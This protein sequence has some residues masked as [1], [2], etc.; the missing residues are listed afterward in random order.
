MKKIKIGQIGIGHN[1]GGEKMLAV[2]RFPELFEVIGYAEENERWIEKRGHLPVYADLPRYS[3]AELIEKCDA[4]L[5]ETG[6]RSMQ[7]YFFGFVF[8]S[9]QFAGQ[10][11]FTAL[12]K[13]KQAVFFSLLRKAF[14]VFPLTL[15]LPKWFDVHGVFLAEPI[16]NLI[17]GVACFATMA[18]TIFPMLRRE[19]A[20]KHL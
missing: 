12:G 5:V 17:G 16:S 2:R 3:V 15:L 7:I 4:V 10:A 18:A 13:A 20:K 19:E 9:M 14:I 8:M 1:H 11:T 6:I